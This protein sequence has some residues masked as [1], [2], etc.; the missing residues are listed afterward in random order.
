MKRI[1]DKKYFIHV[2]LLIIIALLIVIVLLNRYSYEGSSRLDKFTNRL[3]SC[4][5]EDHG[6]GYKELTRCM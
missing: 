3:E 2:C 4:A 5:Y 6:Y 1:I